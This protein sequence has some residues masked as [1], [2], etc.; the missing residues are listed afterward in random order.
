MKPGFPLNHT[1]RNGSILSSKTLRRF[2]IMKLSRNAVFFLLILAAPVQGQQASRPVT[3]AASSEP[4]SPVT[5]QSQED[6]GPGDVVR[7]TASMVSV[8][9][10]VI[11]RQGKYVVD[12][13]QKDFRI[14]EDG[15]EQSISL[16]SNVDQPFSV[17]LLMDT[18]GSTAAFLAQMKE[19]AKSFV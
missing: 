4:Q 5:V 10:S 16:F 8:P 3:P 15:V 9:V 14:Y 13:Q 1:N 12:L 18:S 6:V 7:V 19:A 2:C 17:V 11:D